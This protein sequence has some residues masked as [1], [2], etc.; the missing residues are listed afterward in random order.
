MIGTPGHQKHC[1]L[2]DQ[3]RVEP[4]FDLIQG[5]CPYDEIE[6][7]LPIFLTQQ[8]QGLGGVGI[9]LTPQFKI[10]IQEIG[11]ICNGQFNHT[12]T[13]LSLSDFMIFFMGRISCGHEPDCIQPK[14]LI[15]FP[16][17]PQMTI[18]DGVK[19]P[20]QY[21]YFCQTNP[22]FTYLYRLPA[23]LFLRQHNLTFLF[24]FGRTVKNDFPANDLYHL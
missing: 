2:H 5:I 9:T 7:V 12:L 8:G 3:L 21:S 20:A 6:H 11:S 19:G 15:S 13:H 17:Q 22:F 23:C 1:Q 4:L 10:R 18:V 24:L 14:L 16:A